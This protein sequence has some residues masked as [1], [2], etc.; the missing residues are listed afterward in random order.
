MDEILL[1]EA[2]VNCFS[3]EKFLKHVER[4]Q[5]M[6]LNYACSTFS[7]KGEPLVTKEIETLGL[8]FLTLIYNG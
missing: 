8:E 4:L 1:N 7:I 2:D 3:S 5:E 6:V